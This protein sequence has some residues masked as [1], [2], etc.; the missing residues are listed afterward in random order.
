MMIHFNPFYMNPISKIEA[1]MNYGD[2]DQAGVALKDLGESR[3]TL[4]KYNG[5]TLGQFETLFFGLV[6]IKHVRQ[7]PQKRR[8]KPC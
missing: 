7:R 8:V 5:M 3:T 6:V 4:E 2:I 1:T